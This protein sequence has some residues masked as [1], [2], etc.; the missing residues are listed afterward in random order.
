MSSIIGTERDAKPD[1]PDELVHGDLHFGRH[2]CRVRELHLRHELELRHR[3]RPLRILP[4]HP[5]HH[6]LRRLNHPLLHLQIRD[7]FELAKG[8]RLSDPQRHLQ[9]EFLFPFFNFAFPAVFF[10][11][12]V[13][14][15][16]L[17]IG[18]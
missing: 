18:K 4:G 10:L 16:Q 14:S 5:L 1:N 12:S 2:F 9:V 8:P 3:G 17:T 15:I 13:C 7:Y 6:D 11:I